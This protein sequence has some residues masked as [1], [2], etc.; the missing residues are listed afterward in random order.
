MGMGVQQDSAESGP[1]ERRNQGAREQQLLFGIL[2]SSRVK[3]KATSSKTIS[4]CAQP[5][6]L[7]GWNGERALFALLGRHKAP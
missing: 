3:S 4:F 1:K 6:E 7:M 5:A 2:K